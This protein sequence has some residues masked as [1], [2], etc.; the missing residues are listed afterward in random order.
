MG[1]RTQLF[2]N[3]EDAKGE[4]IL[5]TVIHYQCGYGRVMLESALHIATNMDL[6]DI[7][8]YGK[9][10][11]QKLFESKVFE[12]L[13]DY[14]GFKKPALTYALRNSIGKNIGNGGVLN[15][16]IDEF[17]QAVKEP[18]RD[19]QKQNLSIFSVLDPV[20]EVKDAYA[21]KYEN[22]FNQ[23]DN[24]DGLMFVNMKTAEP[25]ENVNSYYWDASEIKF[26]FGLTTDIYS[27]NP[28]WHPA[29]FEQYA[30]QEVNHGY[31]TE[32]FI[33]GYKLLLKGYGIE[34]MSPEEVKSRSKKWLIKE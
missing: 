11:E 29:T 15:I 8:D 33:E 6:T 9:S 25:I 7:G 19:V 2:I 17:E 23:C 27:M 18:V 31:V 14:C 13:K 20:V 32:D 16:S 24:N 12:I 26:G 1:E 30:R 21:A 34:M 5:G 22:F 28:K 10:D 3:L 4:Q